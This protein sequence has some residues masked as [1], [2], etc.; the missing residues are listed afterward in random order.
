M[1]VSHWIVLF[2]RRELS[3]RLFC[4]KF[5]DI[6]TSDESN[7]VIVDED[8]TGGV[9]YLNV[10]KFHIEDKEVLPLTCTEPASD[11]KIFI[12]DYM[13]K[14]IDRNA[15]DFLKGTVDLKIQSRPSQNENLYYVVAGCN[16]GQS[17]NP[18]LE[19]FAIFEKFREAIPDFSKQ[20]VHCVLQISEMS[21]FGAVNQAY[22]HF[23]LNDLNR[24][25]RVCIAGKFLN[26]NQHVSIECLLDRRKAEKSHIYANSTLFV[27]SVSE[28]AP[29]CIGPYSQATAQERILRLAGQIALI[30]SNMELIIG[31]D[32][33]N[34]LTLQTKQ[35]VENIA[36]VLDGMREATLEDV[37]RC[38]IY[39]N[40]GKIDNLSQAQQTVEQV[41][42]TSGKKMQGKCIHELVSVPD[43][44]RGA[45][46]EIHV[47]AYMKRLPMD[48]P[49][50]FD[51]KHVEVAKPTKVILSN[52]NIEAN[53]Q[54][55][56]IP[57][58]NT[59]LTS[60][61]LEGS[62]SNH[63]DG[64]TTESLLS[65]ANSPSI[66][67]IFCTDAKSFAILSSKFTTAICSPY[68]VSSLVTT[69]TDNTLA[70]LECESL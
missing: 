41:M 66:V 69:T 49:E 32:L 58:S 45:L 31:Q 67:R 65:I 64:I 68:L 38:L 59:C 57:L 11:I 25:S 63:L 27:Q 4:L 51:G 16:P 54:S 60:I 61:T 13:D 14:T 20:M 2:L 36:Q 55:I 48:L 37:F 50:D 30:P 29:A 12:P 6:C 43:L 15:V 17:F 18:A 33:D 40:A 9:G 35:C 46:V 44:P 39:L 62:N 53:V 28:W 22:C 26:E 10:T 42:N 47:F 52:G 23:F 8:Y 21:C 24:P 34:T 56:R 5:L 3:C 70:I 7:V 19:V 1:R